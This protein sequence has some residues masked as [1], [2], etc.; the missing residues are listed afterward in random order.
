MSADGESNQYGDVLAA[1]PTVLAETAL[2]QVHELLT[3]GASVEDVRQV[4][5]TAVALLNMHQRTR[6]SLRRRWLAKV[7]SFTFPRTFSTGPLPA[8]ADVAT[9]RDAARRHLHVCFTVQ[10]TD[11]T[12]QAVGREVEVQVPADDA[13]RLGQQMARIAEHQ[14]ASYREAEQTSPSKGDQM[15]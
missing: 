13:L 6:P 3:S 14:L 12:K 5:T 8:T 10:I 4:A 15:T 11:G 2:R 9:L 1:S 7:T